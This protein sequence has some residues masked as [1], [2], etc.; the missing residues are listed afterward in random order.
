MFCCPNQQ[1]RGIKTRLFQGNQSE[2]FIRP[3]HVMG[4]CQKFQKTIA[5]KN[6][7]QLFKLQINYVSC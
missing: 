2:V 7:F 3:K 6:K 5:T 1:S 4:K